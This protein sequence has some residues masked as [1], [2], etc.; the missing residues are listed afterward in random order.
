MSTG[1]STFL[2]DALHVLSA[3]AWGG[4]L[5]FLAAGLAFTSP[6]DRWPLAARTVP[7]FSA[8]ALGSVAVLLAAGGA[9]AYLE[10]R[11]FRGFVDSTYGA[12][13]LVKIALAIP[14]LALGAFNNRVSVPRLRPAWARS[15]CTVDLRG[16]SAPSYSFSP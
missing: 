12:L 7:R 11:A 8:L 10:V 4:G 1:P 3:A 6:G 14:L 15:P 16:R 2:V 5:A 9:N 13:V